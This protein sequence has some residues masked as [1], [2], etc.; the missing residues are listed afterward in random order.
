MWNN[1]KCPWRV[2]YVLCSNLQNKKT[3][4]TA[5]DGSPQLQIKTGDSSPKLSAVW[6]RCLEVLVEKL[7]AV[8]SN[9]RRIA[10]YRTAPIFP[11]PTSWDVALAY[12]MMSTSRSEM[13]PNG[14]HRRTAMFIDR[15]SRFRW[16]GDG[17]AG[18]PIGRGSRLGRWLVG[19]VCGTN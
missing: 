10:L 2:L 17:S 6:H 14:D 11:R 3:A 18:R 7:Q 19:E 12:P 4:E 16:R 1:S 13:L 8:K 15:H 9:R 5:S